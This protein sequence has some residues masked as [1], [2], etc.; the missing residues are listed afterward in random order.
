M[1]GE[2]RAGA[3]GD[4]RVRLFCVGAQKAGTTTLHDTLAGHPD[5]Y[6]PAQKETHFFARDERFARGVDYYHAE[7]FADVRPDQ[8]AGEVDPEYLYFP[9]AGGRIRDYA[10][11]AHI[12]VLLRDPVDRAYSHYLM[13]VRRGFERYAFEE[14]VAR[15]PGRLEMGEFERIHFSYVDRSR[16]A[17]QLRRYE[18]LFPRQQIMYLF[19]EDLVREPAGEVNRVLAAVGLPPMRLEQGLDRSNPAT[20]PRR[21]W[22]SRLLHGRSP[23]RRAGRRLFPPDGV[24]AGAVRRL[25]A[26]NLD[27]V[28]PPP[29]AARTRARLIEELGDDVAEVERITGRDLS[30][31]LAPS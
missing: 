12:V 23:L 30:R 17:A 1:S 3:A 21:M 4:F 29:V 5:I 9:D 2:R 16:Y 20:R 27:P 18:A 13:S 25:R 6:L 10:P 7:Y 8:L 26:G 11:D 22:L 19:L 24:V 28:E 31:W 14:A 15:E